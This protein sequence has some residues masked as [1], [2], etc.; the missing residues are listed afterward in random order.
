MNTLNKQYKNYNQDFNIIFI[1]CNYDNSG[2]W[3]TTSKTQTFFEIESNK[4]INE[5]AEW[6][7][8]I[9]EGNSYMV[10]KKTTQIDQLCPG[11]YGVIIET[12][13]YQN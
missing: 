6:A 5:V 2:P 9:L 10:N 1:E 4:N 13:V 7:K 3:A 11:V 8:K 12:I